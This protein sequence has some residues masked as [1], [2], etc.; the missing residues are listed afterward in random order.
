MSKDKSNSDKKLP[1]MPSEPCW[2]ESIQ[3]IKDS[4]RFKSFISFRTHLINTLPQNSYK[5]RERNFSY[6]AKRFFPDESLNQLTVKVWKFY[7]N[8]ELLK[9][10]MRF[11]FLYNEKLIAKFIEEELSLFNPGS[12]FNKSLF[13]K[14]VNKVY[15]IP[16]PKAVARIINIL[17]K[18]DYLTYKSKIYSVLSK[19]LPKLPLIIL[20]HHIFAPSP[21]TVIIKNIIM[22]P[23]WKYLSIQSET[24]IRQI[25]KEAAAN[26]LI[27][28]YITADQLEQITTKYSLDEFIQKRIKL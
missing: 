3:A 22:N 17:R 11:Q 15:K 23:F 28:K 7:R 9:D 19:P 14:F 20:I 6:I 2:E 16:K 5:T 10:I 13:E 4:L 27:A 21:K 26:G 24:Q 25:L 1:F 8:E 18:L 12:T